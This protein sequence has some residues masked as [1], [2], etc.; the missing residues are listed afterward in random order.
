MDILISVNIAYYEAALIMLRSLFYNNSDCEIVI[1][2]FY[3]E[4]GER[5]IARIRNLINKNNGVLYVIKIDDEILKNV[6]VGSLSKETYYRL[7]APALLPQHL[8]RILYLDID[9]IITGNIRDIYQVDFQ[10]KFFMAVPDTLL[11]VDNIKKKLRMKKDSVYVNAGVLLMNLKLL[12][13]EFDL[14]RALEYAIRNPE[15]VP[16]C[17][18]DVIN[19]LYYEQ[20]GYL[21]WIY[22]YEARFHSISEI[23]TFPLQLKYL[24]R[25]IKVIHYMGSRK[26]WKSGFNGKF[27]REYYFYAKH[28]SYEK[29]IRRNMYCRFINIAKLICDMMIKWIKKKLFTVG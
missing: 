7:M 15:K 22:N 29:E 13:K 1:Y 3:A 27:L 28:T 14:K 21:D 6:P 23:L 19:A 20:I 18:Q 9:M 16:C 4:L 11:E 26:P 17:D 10:N 8:D 12:R 25:N 5:H 2:L 24:R